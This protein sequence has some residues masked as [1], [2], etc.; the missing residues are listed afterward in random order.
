M[1][2]AVAEPELAQGTGQEM[3]EKRYLI[4][5]CGPAAL[6]AARTL[7]SNGIDTDHFRIV[8]KEKKPSEISGAQFLH[9]PIVG[10]PLKPDGEISIVRIGTADGYAQKV[11]GDP[12]VPTSFLGPRSQTVE[13]WSLIREYERLWEDYEPGIEECDVD[14]K[15]LLNFQDSG[16]YDVIISTIPPQAYCINPVHDFPS[17][18]ILLGDP[19]EYLPVRNMVLYNG[20]REEPWYRISDIFGEDGIE[21]ASAIDGPMMRRAWAAANQGTYGF[22][23]GK[24]PLGTDCDCG[25]GHPTTKLLRAG[26]F[27]T[28]DRKI[29]LHKVPAQVA[30]AL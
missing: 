18:H 17:A 3:K 20:R 30:M 11:Y 19:I 28:W 29:L 9:A 22:G 10:D 25:Y 23:E 8:S 21:Y 13:A 15:K 2:T 4:L 1:T 6:I 5:G 14:S 27:G 12:T 24:K 7:E 26:R 16:V